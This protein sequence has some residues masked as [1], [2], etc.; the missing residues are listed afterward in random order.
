MYDIKEVVLKNK[1]QKKKRLVITF[2]DEKMTVVG[3]FLMTDVPLLNKEA[4]Q[5]IEKVLQYECEQKFFT[6]QRC[7][8]NITKETTT[9]SDLYVDIDGMIPLEPYTI[10]TRTLLDLINMWLK[11]LEQEQNH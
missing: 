4:V 11:R 8:L 7:H 10:S 1:R 6:G 5:L 2:H 3:E 9:I